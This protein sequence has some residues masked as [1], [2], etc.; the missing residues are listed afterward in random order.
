MEQD[1]TDPSGIHDEPRKNNDPG[2]SA[3]RARTRK[4]NASVQLALA[5]ANWDEIATA[6]G[7]PTGRTAKVAV[8]RA[9]EKQLTSTDREILRRFTNAR[10]ERLL[11]SVWPKAINPDHP[12]HLI[13]LT[14]ARDLI[15]DHRKLYGLD[16]PTEVV[17]HNPTA[18]ELE[19]WVSRVVTQS[20]PQVT[21]YDILEG[22]VITD[23]PTAIGE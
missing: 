12:D 13:A 14:K 21:E 23:P 10:L 9:L 20:L 11:R 2:T 1:S 5:G 7:Y 18:H 15:G 19:Q 22:E 6:M 3:G 8:E 4:A 17:V 16:A